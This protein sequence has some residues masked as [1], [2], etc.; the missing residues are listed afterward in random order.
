[1]IVVEMDVDVDDGKGGVGPYESSGNAA[2]VVVDEE[3][4]AGY[5]SVAVAVA[6]ADVTV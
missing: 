6:V 4:Y 2:D 1:V 5:V 3:E